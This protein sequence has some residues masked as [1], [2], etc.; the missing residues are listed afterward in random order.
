MR[1]SESTISLRS[2]RRD[3]RHAHAGIAA[4]RHE[5]RAAFGASPHDGGHFLGGGRAHDGRRSTPVA[6]APIADER[7][8]VGGRAVH[9]RLADDARER[10][11]EGGIRRRA[12]P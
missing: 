7:L 1:A 3:G 4:L 2:A 9:V 6:P 5:G 11:S 8:D 12:S 10:G